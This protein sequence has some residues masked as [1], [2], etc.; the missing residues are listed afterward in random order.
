MT[1]GGV[2]DRDEA[3]DGETDNTFMTVDMVAYL[4]SVAGEVS[5]VPRGV[6]SRWTSKKKVPLAGF[7][8]TNP[9]GPVLY[10]LP[11]PCLA[12]T[13]DDSGVPEHPPRGNLSHEAAEDPFSVYVGNEKLHFSSKK[14]AAS[15]CLRLA[16]KIAA[17]PGDNEWD[18]DKLK[19]LSE[20]R[21]RDMKVSV[22]TQLTRK[23]PPRAWTTGTK[24]LLVV[25]MDWMEGDISK[26]PMSKQTLKPSH[27]RERIFPRVAEA[28]RQMSWGKLQLAVDVVPEVIRFTKPRRRYETEGWPFPGLYNGAVESLDGHFRYGTMYDARDYDLVYA[29]TPQQ[30]PTGTKGVAWV[31]AKGAMCNGC[32]VL[33]ENFQIMVAVHELG[34]NLGLSHASS[35]FLEYGDPLD[36]MGNY[37]DVEGLSYGL[38]YKLKLHW[39]PRSSVI[40]VNDAAMAKLNDRFVIKPFD[41]QAGPLPGQLVGIQLSLHKNPRDLYFSFRKTAGKAAGVYAVLQDKN[42]PNSELIDMACHTPSQKDARLQPG[43]TFVDPTS[44]VVVVV[45]RVTDEAAVVHVYRAPGAAQLAAIRARPKFSDGMYKCPRTCT[46]SDLLVSN[47]QGCSSLAGKGYCASGAI[48]MGGKKYSIKKDLCPQSCNECAAVLSGSPLVGSGGSGSGCDD[49]NV[50]ISGMSCPVIAAKGHCDANTNIGNVGK[51]LCPRSCG[52]CPPVPTFSG[53]NAG[54]YEDP[55]PARTHGGG[56]A[57]TLP[58]ATEVEPEGEE[59]AAPENAAPAPAKKAETEPEKPKEE[60]CTD[61]K[62][63]KDKD[64]HGCPAYRAYIEKGDLTRADACAYDGGKA[65]RHCKETCQTCAGTPTTCADDEAWRD[66]D[67]DGCF[68][69]RDYIRKGVMTRNAACEY[70]GGAGKRHCPRTCQ[71]CPAPNPAICVDSEGWRDKDGHGCSTYREYIKGGHMTVA[72]ACSYDGGIAKRH[73]PRTCEACTAPEA[74][75]EDTPEDEGEADP[76]ACEDSKVWKD[77]DG[78][79]CSDY[80]TYIKKGVMTRDDACSYD[81][82]KAARQC[83]QTCQTCVAPPKAKDDKKCADKQCVGSWLRASGQCFQCKEWPSRCD[84][85]EFKADCPL[86]CGVCKPSAEEIE[87]SED[88]DEPASADCED[89]ECIESWKDSTGKCFKCEDFADDYC[90]VDADFM[91]SCPKSCKLCSETL[92]ACHDD[93]KVS[94]CKEYKSWG[95]CTRHDVGIH[96]LDTCGQCEN[97]TMP[98]HH[99]HPVHDMWEEQDKEEKARSGSFSVTPSALWSLIVGVALFSAKC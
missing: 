73:C 21:K 71:S 4:S 16:K 81:G 36:W 1:K 11:T 77:K 72:D 13:L 70:D 69:Y 47:F 22:F 44:Q 49:R 55:E 64:G 53:G 17:D 94:V 74:L 84:E 5:V 24:K 78:S 57:I 59:Q 27:Y 29:I 88:D 68:S 97:G 18:T 40:K 54:M 45:E 60:E 25:V 7:L 61:S 23:D 93:Y 62:E 98:L 30:A 19:D 89:S 92:P 50:K 38:G 87:D 76:S 43:W 6:V 75:N 39:L 41:S 42:A 99:F 26:K 12:T 2:V 56:A 90:G 48:T 37:P 10:T 58:P 9:E 91:K 46:D 85:A 15:F 31:G 35:S 34:H 86:T 32:E 3:P 33:S 82:G 80:R 95:W 63:W 83:R 65:A 52:N 96:C 14:K 67:G 79:G 20:E 28:F 66:K 8:C 51:D